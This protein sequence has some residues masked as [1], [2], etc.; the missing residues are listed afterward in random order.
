MLRLYD[1]HM[2]GILA[3]VLEGV[4]RSRL[5][6]QNEGSLVGQLDCPRVDDHF[7]A[8]V[9]PDEVRETQ[10]VLDAGP[11]MRVE[12]NRVAGLDTCFEDSHTL[13]LEQ[14]HV[15]GW[16]SHD[17]IESVGPLLLGGTRSDSLSRHTAIIVSR[18]ATRPGHGSSGGSAIEGRDARIT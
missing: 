18:V 17:C 14:H 16:G 3:H 5:S 11:A 1:D 8:L 7:S 6:P 2:D 9:A 10:E 4:W 12:G 15:V 13:V